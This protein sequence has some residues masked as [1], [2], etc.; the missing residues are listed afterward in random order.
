MVILIA[1]SFFDELKMHIRGTC[2]ITLFEHSSYSP[3]GYIHL[4]EHPSS[5]S[6]FQAGAVPPS[7]ALA[8]SFSLPCRLRP[9]LFHA[10]AVPPSSTH[11]FA[12]RWQFTIARAFNFAP[13]FSKP[14]NPTLVILWHS[15]N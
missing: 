7:T 5:S 9:S 14:K 10:V 8:L 3:Y 12:R 4:L 13:Q 2:S 11:G 15:S 6:L 1:T